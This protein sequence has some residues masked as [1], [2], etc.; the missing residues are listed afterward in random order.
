MYGLPDKNAE[1]YALQ[2]AD[3]RSS[4]PKTIESK[5]AV[6]AF[7]NVVGQAG[8]SDRVVRTDSGSI[9]TFS[10]VDGRQEPVVSLRINY[11]GDRGYHA[12]VVLQ[13]GRV[14]KQVDLDGSF[15]AA[16]NKIL[17]HVRDPAALKRG[18]TG[19]IAVPDLSFE[20][21]VEAGHSLKGPAHQFL[22]SKDGKKPPNYQ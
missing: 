9:R 16:V 17:R 22:D 10:I 7:E 6:S 19:V 20:E 3:G 18:K 2:L 1:T 4:E 12:K 21:L 15:E 11:G 5:L 13:R 8:C 14:Q